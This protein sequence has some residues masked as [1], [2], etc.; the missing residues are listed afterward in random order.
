[1]R[2]RLVPFLFAAAAI[3]LVVTSASAQFPGLRTAEQ[4]LADAAAYR[5]QLVGNTPVVNADGYIT[6]GVRCATH[7]LT[8]AEH[9]AAETRTA[10]VAARTVQ[11]SAEALLADPSQFRKNVINV[12]VH[13]VHDG[14]T[15][16]VSDADI[17]EQLDVLTKAFKKH[18]FKFKLKK[19]TRTKHKGRFNKCEKFKFYN[20]MTKKLSV[21]AKKYL[22]IY[23]C[24]PGGGILGFA[25][26]PGTAITGTRYDG[27]VLLYSSLPN[28]SASPYNLGDTGTHEVGHY[29]GLL[30]TFEG[31]CSDEDEVADTPAERSAAYDC[32]VGRDTCP[33]AGDDPI[34]NFMDYT[35]DSCMNKFTKGQRT[36]MGEQ[37]D[38]F[39]PGI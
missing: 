9:A 26:L 24:N 3:S 17:A 28:G 39:R 10:M 4:V 27:V 37:V 11:P 8:A 13:V 34:R 25:Y 5:V 19:T 6:L 15:G 20:K 35:D 38:A 12:Y 22:N 31:G 1:M 18:G 21:N 30:H 7:G 32:P 36:R 14:K 16:N 2:T 23:L 33:S 29:L